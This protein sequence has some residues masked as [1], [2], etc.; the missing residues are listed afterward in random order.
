MEIENENRDTNIDD[1]N[2]DSNSDD[3]A[4]SSDTTDSGARDDI[5]PYEQDGYIIF[6]VYEQD[7]DLTN[8][9]EPIEWEVLGTDSNGT[10]LVSRYILDCQPYNTEYVD[11]TWET[12]SLRAWLN[13]DFLNTAFTPFEQSFNRNA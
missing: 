8:G 6:G 3:N 9:P 13:D 4:D 7:G 5:L 11:V 1:G 2:S 12:C 10:L